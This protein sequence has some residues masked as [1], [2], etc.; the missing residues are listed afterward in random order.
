MGELTRATRLVAAPNRDSRPIDARKGKRL[1][2]G[3]H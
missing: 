3:A 1:R 2:G